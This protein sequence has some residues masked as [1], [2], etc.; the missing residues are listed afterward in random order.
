MSKY[1]AFS[2]MIVALVIGIIGGFFASGNSSLSAMVEKKESKL[3][4]IMQERTPE[5]GAYTD[6]QFLSDMIVHH[7]SA[8]Q[9]SK[10]VLEHTSRKEVRSL[11]V[12]IIEAQTKEIEQMK[13]WLQEWK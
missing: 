1:L 9:M 13:N 11:A 2:L 10:Q 5:S 6:Q 4:V 12:A 3:A 8:V 7:E